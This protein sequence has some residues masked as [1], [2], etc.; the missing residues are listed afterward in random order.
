[1]DSA[2]S[3]KCNTP[4]LICGQFHHEI[5]DLNRSVLRVTGFRS[6]VDNFDKE[7]D[8]FRVVVKPKALF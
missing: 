5:S 1:M 2:D 4:F 7:T 3:D 6:A 8:N